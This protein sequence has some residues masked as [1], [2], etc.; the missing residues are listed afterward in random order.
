[1]FEN[2]NIW[3]IIVIIAVIILVYYLFFAPST[4]QITRTTTIEGYQGV[5]YDYPENIADFY[6]TQSAQL[7]NSAIDTLTFHPSCCGDQWPVPFDG[8][9]ADQIQ[10]T[11]A[12]PGSPSPYVR[13]SYTCARG[14]NGV[15][16]PCV[17]K[18]AY[19]NLVNRGQNI[20][21]DGI[22]QSLLINKNAPTQ[23]NIKLGPQ[24][25]Q[26]YTDGRLL[27]DLRLQRPLQNVTG[28]QSNGSPAPTNNQ[29]Y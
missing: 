26:I 6:V 9:T 16:C 10:K 19:A 15:G 29:H 24:N 4:T 17:P 11:L 21:C 2:K 3:T 5:P 18:D 1:M 25:Q 22:E 20:K 8:L 12:N 14:P 28:V 23:T 13:T 7:Q 27:N